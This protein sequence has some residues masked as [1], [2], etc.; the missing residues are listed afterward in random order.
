MIGA[1]TMA[2]ITDDPD[3]AAAILQDVRQHLEAM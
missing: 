2:R 1:I 3:A